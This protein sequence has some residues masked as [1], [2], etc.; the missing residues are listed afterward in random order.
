MAE[1]ALRTSCRRTGIQRVIFAL[2]GLLFT[3]V[4]ASA[5]TYPPLSSF[6]YGNSA[7]NAPGQTSFVSGSGYG[8]RYLLPKNYNAANKYP[9]IIFLHGIGEVG[10][11]NTSQLTIGGN[12]ALGALSLVSTANPDNQT[13]YP[14]FFV[15]PQSPVTTWS[16]A[17]GAKAIT[18][19]LNT[20]I[21]QYP[22]A[23]DPERVCLTGLSLGGIGTWNVPT[24]LTTNL[25]SCL[26]PQS[27]FANN[28]SAD[29]SV[30]VWAFHG[31][32]DPTVNVSGSDNAVDSL[33]GRGL[34][35]IYTR[36]DSGGH[37]IWPEAYQ[38]PLLLPWIMAQR[39]GQPM[40]GVPGLTINGSSQA[41]N[42]NLSGTSTTAAS[43]TRIGW[44]SSRYSPSARKT[45]GIS[46][47]TTTFTSAAST[48]TSAFVGQRLG[49][50][51]SSGPLYYDIVG[52]VD[53]HTLTLSRT[54][55]TGT[56]TFETYVYGN[57]QNPFPATGSLS[58][59]WGL[60]NIPLSAGANLIQA[61][62]EAASGSG[63]KGGRTTINQAFSV[64]YTAPVGD[65]VSPSIAIVSPTT[66]VVYTNA[67]TT[68]DLSGTA[69][70]NVGV[71]QVTWQSSNGGSGTATGT[72][73]WTV[74]GVPLATGANLITVAARDAANNIATVTITVVLPATMPAVGG[75]YVWLASP[76]SAALDTAANYSPN[77]VFG[78]LADLHFGN[79]SVTSLYLRSA[80]TVQSLSF[81]AG[82]PAYTLRLATTA[83]GGTGANLTFDGTATIN[84][85]SGLAAGQTLGVSDGSVVLN[86][87]L[88]ISN[89]SAQTLTISR[90]VT[91]NA[92]ASVTLQNA[93]TGNG[94]IDI[95]GIIS[96]AAQTVALTQ[97]SA[98]SSLKL[99]G[100]NTYTGQ[101]RVSKGGLTVGSGGAIS[102]ATTKSLV[103]ADTASTSAALN[104]TG[105]TVNANAGGINMLVG[106]ASGASGAINVGSGGTLNLASQLFLGN[107]GAGI[108]GFGALNISGGTVNLGSFLAPGRGSVA[109][110]Q[111][112]GEVMVS[113]G[114]LT[115][116]A[117]NIEVGSFQTYATN[118]SVMT[119]S[120][121]TTTL[122]AAAG[123]LLVGKSANGILNVS[124]SAVVKILNAAASLSLGNGSGVSGIVNL[125]GGTVTTPAIAGG[126]G[127]GY[128][129]FSGGTLKAS[130]ANASF[131]TGVTAAYVYGGGAVIDDGG[132][133]ITLGQP[134]LTPTPGN[135]VSLA[136]MTFS[137]SGFVAPPIVEVFGT[138]TGA[139]AIATIDGSG[140][141]SGVT[142]TCPGAG[143][144][145]TPTLMF[146]G[147]GGTVTPT[148]SASTTANTSGGL[149]KLGTGTLALTG[150]NTYTGTTL[151]SQGTLRGTGTMAG[152]VTLAA[153]ATLAPGAAAAIGTL[154]INNHLTLSNACSVSVR[155]NNDNAA[156]DWVTGLTEVSYGGALIVTNLGATA[157]AGGETFQLFGASG[158]KSGNFS[159]IVI[160]P[161]T[162]ATNGIFDPNTGILTINSA[163]PPIPTTPTNLTFTVTSGTI[164]LSWP[165]NYLGWRLQTQTNALGTGLGTNWF[166]VP[167][168]EQVTATNLPV[169]TTND[170]VLYRLYYEP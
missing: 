38:H 33:R 122:S 57:K 146:T 149:T 120:G 85:A 98:T 136:G 17:A 144:T 101:T 79:S 109:N 56:N 49:I 3:G 90:P 165:S 153:G 74:T 125:N 2:L 53:T 29:P 140:N 162:G 91:G 170:A 18:N 13:A 54:L 148:G 52:V 157:L 126:V 155:V 86:Q 141:I 77:A 156:K 92:T 4:T 6:L 124:G 41:T 80:Q 154:T 15:A 76:G 163:T 5:I 117:N 89:S 60:T 34:P 1:L 147:G 97:N 51:V 95:T 106:T 67:N 9:V 150:T 114:N 103:V 112:R 131:M 102:G 24:H 35:I 23:I 116:N 134:L 130:K 42:L 36:Y 129:N 61:I 71:T 58:P 138:G 65:T 22:G 142:L 105:G 26:V 21:T 75:S 166:P 83:G 50:L 135:G 20:L 88:W 64:S 168:S 123:S 32:D 118:T 19:I 48:F 82:A 133:A 119:L 10:T 100:A 132:Y 110:S 55:A 87:N 11:N 72:A 47:G 113:A 96:D 43:F 99:T 121:G 27:G 7:V 104:I 14:C 94:E 127:P 62:G 137:G 161:A 12:T 167:G 158:A 78:P 169:V 160:L 59:T 31:A 37:S 164:N 115:V 152:P 63:S 159:S 111:N 25:F 93:G 44:G 139:S 28:I 30:P 45:D 81:D 39:R 46:N 68:I 143:Y 69:A 16:D 145:G 128:V 8:Y 84:L 151:V 107:G 70:D 73:N 40:Q 66:A 108:N